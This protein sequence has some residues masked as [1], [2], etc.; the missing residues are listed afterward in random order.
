MNDALKEIKAKIDDEVN[1][2]TYSPLLFFIFS[3]VCIEHYEIILY[4]LDS[5]LSSTQKI[6][7]MKEYWDDGENV[8][9][10]FL[11]GASAFLVW[12]VMHPVSALIWDLIKRLITWVKKT[13]IH[14]IPVI[15][16][17]DYEALES[18]YIEEKK[19][20]YKEHAEM[21]VKVENI[22]SQLDDAKNNVQN[23]SDEIGRLKEK[24]MTEREQARKSEENLLE[25]HKGELERLTDDFERK[26]KEKLSVV[27][28]VKNEL[29][30]KE[31]ELDFSKKECMS[32]KLEKFDMEHWEKESSSYKK[33][34]FRWRLVFDY[35]SPHVEAQVKEMFSINNIQVQRNFSDD[36]DFVWIKGEAG[37]PGSKL[38]KRG[39]EYIDIIDLGKTKRSSP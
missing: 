7:L 11:M 29:R 4:L 10:P 33:L 13:K 26:V 14:K 23:K 21:V 31:Q 8:V 36:F 35:L 34:G 18:E 39:I 2:R 6:I 27:N 28:D 22:K 30:A 25:R 3:A 1:H 12:C 32:L 20:L 16:E 9:R 24:A 15:P 17:S 19:R 5:S 38:H 37:T